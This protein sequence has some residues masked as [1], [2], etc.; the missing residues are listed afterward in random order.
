MAGPCGCAAGPPGA[1]GR[2]LPHHPQHILCT[3][4]ASGAV[5]GASR[6]GLPAPPPPGREAAR[7]VADGMRKR[8]HRPIRHS[9][10]GKS[11]LPL[12]SLSV[13]VE[14]GWRQLRASFI[15]QNEAVQQMAEGPPAALLLFYSVECG[16]KASLLR[17]LKLHST[18][19]LRPEFRRHDLHRL[20]KE[21]RLPPTLCDRM[22]RSCP[23]QHDQKT[24]ISFEDLHQAWRYGHALQRD[25]EKQ[26]IQVLR[27]LRD[28]YQGELRA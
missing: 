2:D 12:P 17:R 27:E 6:F 25:E 1:H 15:S 18:A 11:R 20:A 13:A 9:R 22:Q 7:T 3:E 4:A 14:V 5:P 24:R 10:C 8:G 28:W 19:Q 16:L 23:S 21:L 26:A